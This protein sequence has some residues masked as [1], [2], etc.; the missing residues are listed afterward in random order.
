MLAIL[1][2]DGWA[3]APLSGDAPE[4][5]AA[6]RPVLAGPTTRARRVGPKAQ[7]CGAGRHLR[8]PGGPNHPARMTL[9]APIAAP[10]GL[11]VLLGA[12]SLQPAAPRW[13]P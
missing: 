13:T 9:P 7:A 11:A 12:P 6:L 2:P 1:P 3:P 10:T 8:E 5:A 4:P